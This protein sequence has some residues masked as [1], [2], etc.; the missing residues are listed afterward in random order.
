MK[1][2]KFSW[3]ENNEPKIEKETAYGSWE[4][5]ER[6][7]GMTKEQYMA[8]EKKITEELAETEVE[9]SIMMEG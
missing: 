7:T 2:T 6:E 4:D 8:R 9:S 1:T 3:Y 5:F